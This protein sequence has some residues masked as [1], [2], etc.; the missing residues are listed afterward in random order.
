MFHVFLFVRNVFCT[1]KYLI[2]YAKVAP[3]IV[4]QTRAELFEASANVVGF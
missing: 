1:D 2:S 3:E 4:T